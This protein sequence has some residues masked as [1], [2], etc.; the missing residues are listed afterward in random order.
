MKL[1][2]EHTRMRVVVVVVVPMVL[3]RYASIVGWICT[4]FSS[5]V[6]QNDGPTN[7]KIKNTNSEER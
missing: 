5:N 2:V 3:L 1:I 6:D 7:N 4:N